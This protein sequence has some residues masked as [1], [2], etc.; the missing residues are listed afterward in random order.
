[1]S[2]N[3]NNNNN[4]SNS[5]SKSTTTEPSSSRRRSCRRSRSITSVAARYPEQRPRQA[6]EKPSRT[7][8]SLRCRR[9]PANRIPRRGSPSITSISWIS[10]VVAC[11][12]SGTL[13]NLESVC[14]RGELTTSYENRSCFVYR[15]TVSFIRDINVK[16]IY[17]QSE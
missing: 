2:N 8:R 5:S 16:I 4:S 13:A 9:S 14:P 12:R 10:V 3:S 11:R 15:G 7:R 6:M 1:M 17:L